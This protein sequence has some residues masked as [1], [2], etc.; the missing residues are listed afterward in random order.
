VFNLKAQTKGGVVSGTDQVMYKKT[1]ER[2]EKKLQMSKIKLSVSHSENLD[3]RNQIDSM[4]R[5]K[6]LYLQI[7]NDLVE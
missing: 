1:I 3:C 6:V 2:L 4:R 7:L 5:D